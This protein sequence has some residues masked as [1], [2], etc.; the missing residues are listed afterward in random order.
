MITRRKIPAVALA[1]IHV[2]FCL[3][4]GI[5]YFSSP[6][7]EIDMVFVVFY[8]LDPWVIPFL[9]NLDYN[10]VSFVCVSI[11]GTGFW[12]CIGLLGGKFIPAKNQ[13]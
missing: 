3:L 5:T 13:K 6:D 8:F 2:V 4:L 9:G 12:W 7:P 1:A 11:I 10:G